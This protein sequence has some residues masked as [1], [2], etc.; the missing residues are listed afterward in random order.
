MRRATIV[1]D[2]SASVAVEFAIVLPALVMLIVGTLYVGI[3]MYSIAGLH[4]AVEAAARCYSIDSNQCGSASA[5]ES[6]GESHYYGVS[7]PAFSAAVA[8][9]GHQVSASLTVALSTGIMNW[10]IPVSATACY[11]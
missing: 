4:S 7:T 11:P 10:N 5:A 3:A 8:T 2:T 9:C 1:H 6:F